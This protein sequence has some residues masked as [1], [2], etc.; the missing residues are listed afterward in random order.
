MAILS[1]CH[2]D[3][4]VDDAMNACSGNLSKEA[5]KLKKWRMKKKYRSLTS[6][7]VIHPSTVFNDYKT[8][9]WS[10]F[11]EKLVANFCK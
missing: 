8:K 11:K 6:S 10:D 9:V 2:F 7:D 1:D 3:A 4:I 5:L